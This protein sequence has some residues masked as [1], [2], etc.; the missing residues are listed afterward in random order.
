[1]QEPRPGPNSQVQASVTQCSELQEPVWG[2]TKG[3]PGLHKESLWRSK[4]DQE[5][6]AFFT[7]TQEEDGNGIRPAHISLTSP[8]QGG[9]SRPPVPFPTGAG[10][11]ATLSSSPSMSCETE[12]N[13]TDQ[14]LVG[15]AAPG[16]G[17]GSILSKKVRTKQRPKSRISWP[18]AWYGNTGHVW[19]LNTW[20][21]LSAAKALNVLFQ[22]I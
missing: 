21:V 17:Q 4:L 7:W 13:G 16:G 22:L 10:S 14:A 1:M 5:T 20:N 15:G 19:L 18:W 11:S 6:M 8:H 3:G 9:P 2:A 12:R